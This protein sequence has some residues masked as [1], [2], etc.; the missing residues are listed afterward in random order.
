MKRYAHIALP[1]PLNSLF[2]YRIPDSLADA[3]Q[4][5]VRALIQFGKRNLTGYVIALAAETDL[6]PSL[7]KNIEDI[8]DEIPA[9]S[10]EILELAQWISDYY[11]CPLGEVLKAMLPAGIKLESERQF[12]IAPDFDPRLIADW[13]AGSSRQ[14]EIIDALRQ[15]GQMNFKQLEKALGSKSLSYA[16]R[17]LMN[18]KIIETSEEMLAPKVKPKFE[19]HVRFREAWQNRDAVSSEI[20]RLRSKY[21]GRAAILEWLKEKEN[22][23]PM[24][25]ALKQTGSTSE[26]LKKVVQGGYI[27]IFDK[28]VFRDYYQNVPEPPP[29]LVLNADQK[30]VLEILSDTLRINEFKAFLLHGVTGSGKTQVY[31][32]ALKM[33]LSR[34]KGAIV[35]VPEIS[36]TPQTVRRFQSNFPGQVA[37]LHSR[38]S[39]G[40]RYDSWRRLRSG[41]FKIAVG[42]RSAIF[43]PIENIGLI[44]VDEEHEASYKQ[45][46]TNPLYHARDVAVMRGK[47]NQAAVIL[48][49]ATP[50]SE[51]YHN[52]LNGKYTYLHLPNRIDDIPMPEVKLV[53]MMREHRVYGFERSKIFSNLLKKKIQEKLELKEQIIL[54]QNRRGYASYLKCKEC[55]YVEECKHCS[56]TLTYHKKH[57]HLRCHYCGYT[58]RAPDKCPQCAGLNIQY[59]GVGTQ[60][61]EEELHALFPEARVIRMDLDTTRGK[62]AHDRIITSFGNGKYD[63]LLGTQMVAKGLDFHRVTLV[64]VISADT[65]LLLPDFRAGERTFQLLTQVAGRAGRKERK[66]EVIIQTHSP[67]NQCL[68]FAQKHDFIGYYQ[69]EEKPRKELSYPPFGKLANILFKGPDEAVLI[70]HATRM[71]KSIAAYSDKLLL[72]GPAP[73]P[74]FKIENQFRWQIIIKSPRTIDPSGKLLRDAIR[75]ALKADKS[76]GTQPNLKITVDIDPM[77]MF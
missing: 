27:E 50:S 8:L 21:P 37:V 76:P 47:L 55:G 31:I 62:L 33:A 60:Q 34:G 51:S 30:R 56:I 19:K 61:V 64:G 52:A 71:A 42:A 39:P 38:M 6:E 44:V 59:K 17:Q 66:G 74:L 5:G 28:E 9:F 14:L 46:E 53:D 70:Q 75:A 29:K 2:T 58:K 25:L 20:D 69:S 16:L 1:L 41:Q 32:D 49:S 43:A 23:V 72:L 10:A 24:R 11:L 65:G 68:L 57:T 22:P 36:L 54:L 4:P 3:T 73:S 7:I 45:F 18:Q 48:G 13:K 77:S 12:R 35:L 63:I 26:T 67:G 15:N 40:E